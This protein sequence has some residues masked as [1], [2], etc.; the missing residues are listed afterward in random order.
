MK[1]QTIINIA[2]AVSFAGYIVWSQNPS[3]GTITCRELRVVDSAKNTRISLQ[4]YES[5]AESQDL[6]YIRLFTEGDPRKTQVSALDISLS[7]KSRVPDI[8]FYQNQGVNELSG[9]VQFVSTFDASLWGGK[10][11]VA[12]FTKLFKQELEQKQ[13]QERQ[14]K[15]FK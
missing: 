7:G 10:E 15:E 1:S 4:M 6:A 12:E 2:F 11:N 14:N 8:S 5:K 13:E 9:K 3:V